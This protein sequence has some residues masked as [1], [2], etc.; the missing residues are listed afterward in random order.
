MSDSDNSDDGPS[1]PKIKKEKI[2]AFN[3]KWLE[4]E[5][6]KF[7]LKAVPENKA[8]CLCKVC[9]K[10]LACG[11]S[12]LIKHSEGV[13]HIKNMSAIKSTPTLSSM[14][15]GSKVK[16]KNDVKVAEIKLGVF[17]MEHNVATHIVDHLVP[18]LK[19][20]FPDSKICNEV[21]L[22]RTK[23]TEIMKNVVGKY[24][25]E[26][27]V[28]VL[29]TN[30]FSILV[31]ESTDIGTQKAM[32]LLVRFPK[33]FKIQTQLLELINLDAQ[34]CSAAK[35][36]EQ[37]KQC[38]NKYN[39]PVTNII[40]VA[41]DGANVMIGEKN[42]FFSH[43]KSDVPSAI[44]IR[45]ICHSAAIIAN[46][47]C[48]TL[49]RSS[50]DLVRSISSY[51][52]GSAKRCKILQ[53]IQEFMELE[54]TKILHLSTTRWLS[55]HACIERILQ[56]WD[57]LESFFRLAAFEDKLKS[58]E[59]ILAEL[60]NICTK[61]YLYFLKYVLH[62]VNS[63]NALFQSRNI[64]I[65]KLYDS[66]QKLMKQICDNF[67]KPEIVMEKNLGS[68]NLKHPDFFLP[69]TSIHLG[70]EC[71]QLVKNM[72]SEV[73]NDFLTKCLQ[74]YITLATEMQKRLPINDDFF[75]N[76]QFL[77]PTFAFYHTNR[78]KFGININN[79]AVLFKEH[80]DLT[81]VSLEWQMLPSTYNEFQ[82][83]EFSKMP[84]DEM[85]IKIADEKNF[86][87]EDIF[88]NLGKLAILILSLPHSNAE[89]ER[90]FSAVTDI[91]TKK[92]NRIGENTLNSMC[93]LRSSLSSNN[94]NCIKYNVSEAHLKLHNT[95]MY[96]FKKNN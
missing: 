16:Q 80:L 93:V 49:P 52:S 53:D 4:E 21:Q 69:L 47:A 77:D 34:D 82:I 5:K 88:Q 12:E 2:K 65:H 27:L 75:K 51:I 26:T 94:N 58:A 57:A 37:F 71:E 72:P 40:G 59:N 23:C 85:W 86:S 89:A 68:L 10:V 33:N 63:F 64:L 32:C 56:N 3:L 66:S 83:S 76:M 19:N 13:K 44:C 67:M 46:K 81:K 31:D 84:I 60:Q 7:W 55:R 20:I 11:K 74:F 95:A 24:E 22:C 38:L 43:L 50:E 62:F 90:I 48:E 54:K 1:K 87:D 41:S 18:L 25:T 6:F 78:L 35:L 36:Y 15:T 79:L 73:K 29:K 39:I 96:D 9:N 14:M 92:R 30:P 45:C 8:K 17:F 28:T 42:S 70:I 91:K 61:G